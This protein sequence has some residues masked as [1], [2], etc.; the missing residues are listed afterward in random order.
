MKPNIFSTLPPII[1]WNMGRAHWKLTDHWNNLPDE[2][3]LFTV[4]N[5]EIWM[6]FS[7]YSVTPISLFFH[8]QA[9]VSEKTNGSLIPQYTNIPPK[10][11]LVYYH[12]VFY[13]SSSLPAYNENS[14]DP[15]ALTSCVLLD[16]NVRTW[17]PHSLPL[18]G[19]IFKEQPAVYNGCRQFDTAE[20]LWGRNNLYEL[21]R[22]SCAVQ[23]GVVGQ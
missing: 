4:P 8:Q 6:M 5:H 16:Q 19:G 13:T 2:K 18:T 23:D 14:S 9:S 22:S 3:N 12:G 21:Y 15:V 10:I 1:N 11:P 7:I 20:R 17:I